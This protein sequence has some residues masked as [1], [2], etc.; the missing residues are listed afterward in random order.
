MPEQTFKESFK[1]AADQLVL[2]QEGAGIVKTEKF[3]KA[4]ATATRRE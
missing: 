4:D 3:A 2:I 1:V